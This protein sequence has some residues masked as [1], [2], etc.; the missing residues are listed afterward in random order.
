MKMIPPPSS[1]AYAYCTDVDVRRD[2]M[3]HGMEMFDR[4]LG[5]SV[6]EWPPSKGVISFP[7]SLAVIIMIE[8]S[9]LARDSWS[10]HKHIHIIFQLN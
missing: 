5:N 10:H 8:S 1:E 2:R 6:G 7:F 3:G 9:S 4:V